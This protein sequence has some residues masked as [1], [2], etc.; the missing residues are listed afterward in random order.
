MK[1]QT[2]R[3]VWVD[4]ET[5]GLDP[6]DHCIL[7]IAMVITD[8]RLEVIDEFRRVNRFDRESIRDL[9]DPVVDQMHEKS[10]LWLE[11]VKNGLP[12]YVVEKDAIRFIEEHRAQLSPMCGSSVG[13][14]DRPFLK[15]D[16]PKLESRFHYR[17]FDASMYRIEAELCDRLDLPPKKEAHRALDDIRESIALAKWG[18]RDGNRWREILRYYDQPGRLA[19]SSSDYLEDAI[20]HTERAVP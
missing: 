8:R 17:N 4:L 20:E 11:C 3:L 2:N 1:M 7:E 16:M 9:L 5:T 14:V 19:P 12:I 6:E 18:M 13:A 10:G 15:S